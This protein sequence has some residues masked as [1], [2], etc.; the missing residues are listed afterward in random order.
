MFFLCGGIISWASKPIVT[1]SSTEAEYIAASLSSQEL[2]WIRSL[3]DNLNFKQDGPTILNEDDQ[4]TIT[5]SK[6]PKCHAR[7]KHI[8]I[9]FHFIREKIKNCEIKLEY[10]PSEDMIADML[11]KPLGK[12]KYKRFRDL[13]C[14]CES[15]VEEKS[16]REETREER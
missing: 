8:G 14:V 11:T 13:M 2:I 10:C 7:A 3:L 9:K 6:N 16:E 12:I 15:V 1:L 4:R 5:L